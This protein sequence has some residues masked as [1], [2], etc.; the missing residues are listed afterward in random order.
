MRYG[1][2]SIVDGLALCLSEL[3]AL[4]VRVVC[5]RCVC[6]QVKQEAADRED[7][8]IHE[9]SFLKEQLAKCSVRIQVCVGISLRRG[10]CVMVVQL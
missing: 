4:C 2:G 5:P 1:R 8:H 10:V 7:Q 6:F 3:I 9:V